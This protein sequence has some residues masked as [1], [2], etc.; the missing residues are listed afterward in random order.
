MLVSVHVHQ[1]RSCVD[2]ELTDLNAML[3]LLGRNGVG[4]TNVLLAIEWAALLG[5]SASG[6]VPVGLGDVTGNVTLGMVIDG[7]HYEYS[8]EVEELLQTPEEAEKAEARVFSEY[9]RVGLEGGGYDDVFNRSGADVRY[10]IDGK[11][12]KVAPSSPAA[13]AIASL[14]PN[15]PAT[16]VIRT[17][18]SFLSRL[19]YLPLDTPSR[20]DIDYSIVRDT[21]YREFKS[22]RSDPI[23]KESRKILLQL[24]DLKKTKP[25][26]FDEFI[27]LVGDRGLGIISDLQISEFRVP[28][29]ANPDGEEVYHY[30]RWQPVNVKSTHG[31]GFR[32]LSYGT[33]RLLRLFV[34]LLYSSP[35]LML[36]EQPEDGIHKGLLHKLIPALQSY[37]DTCQIIVATHAAEILNR[38]QPEQIRLV[39][40]NSGLTSIRR[41]TD[42]EVRAAYDYMKDEGALADFLDLVQG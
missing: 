39:E 10:G 20:E 9:L 27:S 13:F 19:R 17:V 7:K 1:F 14:A 4:K 18:M 28:E 34:S 11:H 24:L 37:C 5:S 38:G 21:E 41:L 6:A 32:D 40:M 35:T 3:M 22:R 12:L 33:R 26:R 16:G 30:F 8:L 29:V 2:V 25:E 42:D 15:D 31:Y 36:I 23:K